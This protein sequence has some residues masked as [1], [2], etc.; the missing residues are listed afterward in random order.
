MPKT[1]HGNEHEH[2]HAV[3]Q[4]NKLALLKGKP[5]FTRYIEWWPNRI[6][7]WNY[8]LSEYTPC[9]NASWL[10]RCAFILFRSEC[11][12]R[13]TIMIFWWLSAYAHL[14]LRFFRHPKNAFYPLWQTIGWMQMPECLSF[15]PLMLFTVEICCKKQST[16]FK[17]KFQWLISTILPSKRL[18][19]HIV[20][21]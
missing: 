18:W 9:S 8:S 2:A 16:I 10:N 4:I 11:I 3:V 5:I 19:N 14:T 6:P 17:S 1:R 13:T 7:N 15:H 20:T 12:M 21:H